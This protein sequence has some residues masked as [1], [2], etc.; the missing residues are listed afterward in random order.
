MIEALK[1]Q[2]IFT[3]ENTSIFVYREFPVIFIFVP[4]YASYFFK[5][6]NMFDFQK[7]NILENSLEPL[8]YICGLKFLGCNTFV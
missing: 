1:S 2:E 5:K 8:R 6:G 7:N 4:S 3:S